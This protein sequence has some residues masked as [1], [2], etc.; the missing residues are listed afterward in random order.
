MSGRTSALDELKLQGFKDVEAIQDLLLPLHADG[1]TRNKAANREFFLQARCRSFCSS[2][3]SPSERGND[4][5]C[6][7]KMPCPG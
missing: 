1:S 7:I 4:L 6:N 2:N 3:N 5:N